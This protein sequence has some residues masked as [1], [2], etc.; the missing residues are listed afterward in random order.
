MLLDTILAFVT[1]VLH[2][3]VDLMARFFFA[4]Q[5][6]A[7]EKGRA[8]NVA[9]VSAACTLYLVTAILRGFLPSLALTLPSVLFAWPLIIL[10]ILFVVVFGPLLGVARDAPPLPDTPEKPKL[11]LVERYLL[12]TALSYTL[13]FTAVFGG[14]SLYSSTVRAPRL[15]ESTCF[16]ILERVPEAA[17][18]RAVLLSENLLD[19]ELKFLDRC[20]ALQKDL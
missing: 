20:L 18:G 6:A 13:A 8:R 17:I 5:V 3:L 19:R 10:A 11:S 2:L 7:T 14:L 9:L 1:L 4:L 16:K 15:I 12:S